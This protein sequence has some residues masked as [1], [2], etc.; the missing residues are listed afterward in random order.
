MQTLIFIGLVWAIVGFVFLIFGFFGFASEDI[1]YGDAKIDLANIKQKVFVF[2]ICGPFSWI[3]GI[4]G[5]C[6]MFYNWLGNKKINYMKKVYFIGG[7]TVAH[8]SNHLALCTPAYGSTANQLCDIWIEKGYDKIIDAYSLFTKMGGGC[9]APETNEDVAV[10]IEKLKL[11]NNTK[12]IFF[13]CAL[14]DFKPQDILINL[15]NY[16]EDSLLITRFG[17]Y[18][19]RLETNKIKDI[20]LKIV[21]SEKII[22]NI[23]TGRKDIFLVGFKTTCSATKQEMFEKGLNLCKSSSVNLVLVNDTKTRWNMIVT[24]EEVTYHETD[25]R[26]EVLEGLVEMTWLRSQ[27]TFTQSTVM[28]GKPISWNDNRVPSSLKIIVDH[29]VNNKAYKS[30]K[31]ATVG[32]FAVRLSETEFL[33]SIRKS[34]F[35]KLNE[36]GLVYVKTD[37]PDTVLAYGAKPSVGAQSQRIIFKDHPGNDCI[38]HFHCPLRENYSDNIPIRSQRE[39]ECGSHQCGKNTSNGLKQFGN[40]KAVMLDQ[41][42]PNIIFNRSI[43]PKEVIDFIECNFDLSKKTGGYQLPI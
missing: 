6:I 24:P 23:R 10:E 38:V 30:F 36:I 31:G 26:R 37:G 41:H 16:E 11:D 5:L 18:E 40:L 42:G 2:C 21:P 29:C 28:D 19:N 22:K 43:D 8:I 1:H 35:N 12:I 15:N 4:I 13:S 3:L 25:N 27:L 33:T 9:N 39:V 14:V 7:G 20:L 17:K 32:H 34:N